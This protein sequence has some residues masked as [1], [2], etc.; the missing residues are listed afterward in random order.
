MPQAPQAFIR[1][2][3][4]AIIILS[5]WCLRTTSL[6]LLI[7][8][9]MFLVITRRI[10]EDVAS[11]LDTPDDWF[12]ALTTPL[13]GLA[14][15]IAA[16]VLVAALAWLS[17]AWLVSREV[18]PLVQVDGQSAWRRTTDRWRQISGT[19]SVRGTWAVRTAAIQRAGAWGPRLRMTDILLRISCG[20][21]VVALVVSMILVG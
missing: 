20:I 12:R 4:D 8:G 16:R 1:S 3:G 19:A 11:Q 6:L 9:T 21:T 18:P 5:L 2:R 10:G 7:L 13:A 17:A 15:A 14:L